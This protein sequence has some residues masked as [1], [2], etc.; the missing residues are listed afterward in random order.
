MVSH[1]NLVPPSHLRTYMQEVMAALRQRTM[2]LLVTELVA[3]FA[4]QRYQLE[5]FIDAIADYAASQTGWEE[6]VKHLEL[7]SKS[8][9]KVRRERG[10]FPR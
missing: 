10:D 9:V 2:Q 7:A 4:T 3:A 1:E 5:E 8:V 6:V